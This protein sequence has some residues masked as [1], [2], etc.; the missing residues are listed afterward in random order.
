MEQFLFH[1]GKSIYQMK[2][3]ISIFLLCSVFLWACKPFQNTITLA[4][5][6]PPI[7]RKDISYSYSSDQ[8]NYGENHIKKGWARRNDV[9]VLQVK[10]I[11]NT[12][13]NLHGSQFK[14]FSNGEKLE[15]VNH[16]LASKKLKSKKFPSAVYIVP[17]AIVAIIIYAGIVNLLDG[18]S[19]DLDGDGFDD[20]TDIGIKKSDKAKDPLYGLNLI[21]KELYI[22]NIAEKIIEPGEQISGLIA[23]RSKEPINELNIQV[24]KAGFEVYGKK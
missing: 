4:R 23:F 20:D 6:E 3:T 13:H 15:I 11:N 21:Q 8:I 22:F 9:Q 2:K 5:T 19:E 17:V 18:A 14:F 16:Q 1:P 24:E 12:D 10:I 7:L